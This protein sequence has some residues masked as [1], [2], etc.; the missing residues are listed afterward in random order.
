MLAYELFTGAVPFEGRGYQE[1]LLRD[2]RVPPSL[3][4]RA[5][6]FWSAMGSE[7]SVEQQV[8]GELEA[9]GDDER[10]P[11]ERGAQEQRRGDERRRGDAATPRLRAMPVTPAAAAR[12]SGATIAIV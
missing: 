9:A 12:S 2:V 5:N 7:R 11:R 6:L 4:V 8:V 3:P 10:R 1:V